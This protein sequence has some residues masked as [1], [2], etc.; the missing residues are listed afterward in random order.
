M[1]GAIEEASSQR[2]RQKRYVCSL[3]GE[4]GAASHTFVEGKSR[5]RPRILRVKEKMPFEF[6]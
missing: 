2:M 4:E 6:G 5:E 1:I 3:P